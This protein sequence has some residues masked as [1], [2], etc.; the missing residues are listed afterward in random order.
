MRL[1]LE[2]L[3]ERPH[4]A[5]LA[6]AGLARQQ[7]HLAVALLGPLPALEQKSDLMLAADQRRQARPMQ[8]LEPAFGG[9][10]PDHAPSLHRTG[11]ALQSMQAEVGKIEQARRSAAGCGR[12]SPRSR[13][14]QGLQ[15]RREVRGVA[16]HR[17]LARRAFTDQLADDHRAGGDADTS[18]ERAACADPRLWTAATA[19]RPARTARS[20]SSSWARG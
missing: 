12:R 2:P 6:D 15:P 17:L 19:A 3:A 16:D 4:K 18:R 5:R 14:G 9:A 7:H 10:F 8:R 13:L 20:A 1:I 11:K